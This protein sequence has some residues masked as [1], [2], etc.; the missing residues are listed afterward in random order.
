MVLALASGC[1]LLAGGAVA[2]LAWRVSRRRRRVLHDHTSHRSGGAAVAEQRPSSRMPQARHGP[3]D[4]LPRPAS[5]RA[6]ARP[7]IVLPPNA[8]PPTKL[9]TELPPTPP[10][11]PSTAS[12]PSVRGALHST[13]SST[14]RLRPRTLV[15]SPRPKSCA[16]P[17]KLSASAAMGAEGRAA[18]S[19]PDP[20]GRGGLLHDDR[21]SHSPATRKG[22]FPYATPHDRLWEALELQYEL[23]AVCGRAAPVTPQER[24]SEALQLQY[25]LREACGRAAPMPGWSTAVEQAH[26]TSSP[27]KLVE[28]SRRST[29]GRSSRVDLHG[30]QGMQDAA[31]AGRP[32]ECVQGAALGAVRR[33]P[34]AAA[35]SASRQHIIGRRCNLASRPHSTSAFLGDLASDLP[36]TIGSREQQERSTR[37]QQLRRA[38]SQHRIR[39]DRNGD[40][41]GA[42][43]EDHRRPGTRL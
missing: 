14:P 23:R 25:E 37:D 20:I 12:A 26:S 30:F 11:T 3:H 42:D 43:G 35:S 33:L 10:P 1:V 41:R 21:R 5:R 17:A 13:C 32:H 19:A 4:P 9:A 24:L 7:P 2:L 31:S 18:A 8:L 15:S 29:S 34:A 22:T 16:T 28:M 36:A 38:R 40:L 6:A 27:M 39:A